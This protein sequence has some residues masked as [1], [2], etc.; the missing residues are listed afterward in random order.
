MTIFRP[1]NNYAGLERGVDDVDRTLSDKEQKQEE[2]DYRNGVSEYMDKLLNGDTLPSFLPH[3]S[4][5]FADGMEE[6]ESDTEIMNA[7]RAFMVSEKKEDCEKT[8][9][10]LKNLLHIHLLNTTKSLYE[11]HKQDGVEL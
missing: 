7:M 2:I 4:H 8:A 3:Y 11:S 9:Y 5:T 10:L 1:E 6:I